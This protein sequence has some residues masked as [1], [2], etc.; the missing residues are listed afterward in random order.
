MKKA[1]YILSGQAPE[2]WGGHLE[3]NKKPSIRRRLFYQKFILLI[4]ASITAC[5]N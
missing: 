4:S 3:K 2:W 1:S 5:W